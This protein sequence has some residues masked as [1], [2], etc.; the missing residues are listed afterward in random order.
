[1][2]NGLMSYQPK[3]TASSA[4]PKATQSA[5]CYLSLTRRH[6]NTYHHRTMRLTD[7]HVVGTKWQ[8]TL[9]TS[10]PYLIAQVE[11]N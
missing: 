10:P 9:N 1:M 7:Y 2:I 5:N 3:N 8:L 4:Q 6:R 11:V